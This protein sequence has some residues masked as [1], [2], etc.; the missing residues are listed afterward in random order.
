MKFL[1]FNYQLLW[2]QKDQKTYIH[3]PQILTE[4]ELLPYIIKNEHRYLQ[5]RDLHLF[6]T[7]YFEQINLDH[8]FIT[9]FSETSDNRPYTTSNVS[10]E[11]T[12]EEQTSNVLPQHT[13]QNTIQSEQEDL[14]NFFQNQEP[15]QLNPLYPQLS[16]ASDIQQL[17][18]SETATIQT[19]SEFSEET[20][21]TVQN[22]QSLTVTNDSNLI[23]VPTHIIL[24]GPK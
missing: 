24:P 3:F 1:R 17:N 10:P 22:T 19:A 4:T 12:P 2:G 20:V 13:R 21:Q 9:E 7:T 5:Y 8:N 23:Q 16:Q 18:P 15:H 6:N 14:V 11:T